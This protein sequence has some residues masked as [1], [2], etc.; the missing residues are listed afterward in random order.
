LEYIVNT[1]VAFPFPI[2]GDVY[3]RRNSLSAERLERLEDEL[4]TIVNVDAVPGLF[5][6]ANYNLRTTSFFIESGQDL[7]LNNYFYNNLNIAPGRWNSRLSIVNFSVGIGTNFEEYIGNLPEHY[8][9][10]VLVFGPLDRG[11]PSSVSN[12]NNYFA[13]AQF[14]PTAQIVIWGKRTLTKGGNTYYHIPH[15]TPI[16]RDELK[17]EYERVRLGYFVASYERKNIQSYPVQTDQNLYLEWNKPWAAF[18]RTKVTTNYRTDEDDYA[19]GVLSSEELKGNLET[20]L[21]FGTKSY[22]RFYLGGTKWTDQLN[23]TDYAVVPGAGL[24]VNLF[25]FLYLQFDYEST[26]IIDGISTHTLSSRITGQF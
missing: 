14:T 19:V 3:Y 11:Y 6:T 10:P 26:H 15:L 7:K 1:N 16:T 22:A 17:I 9:K 20:L 21:R 24:N 4:R 2:S 13:A 18:L 23:E 8:R 5:Y 12:V 25:T